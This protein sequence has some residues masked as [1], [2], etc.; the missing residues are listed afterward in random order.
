[1]QSK[2]YSDPQEYS[3][4]AQ[5]LQK[6]ELCGRSFNASALERHMKVCKKVF[7]TKR[8][9]MDMEKRRKQGFVAE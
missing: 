6:C 2:E 3:P 8:K 4:T 5:E 1:M 9:P 7:S